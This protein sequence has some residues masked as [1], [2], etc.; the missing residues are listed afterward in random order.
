MNVQGMS[1]DAAVAQAA[2]T[3][4]VQFKM[5]MDGLK[6]RLVNAPSQEKQLKKACQD[7]EAVFISKIWQQ[8]RASVPK[9]GYLHS[10]DEEMY[11]SMFD[12]EFS[13]KMAE[14]GGMGLGDMMF[15]QL[16]KKLASAS[17]D[18]LPGQGT[19]ALAPLKGVPQAEAAAAPAA[20]DPVAL[21]ES[22]VGNPAVGPSSTYEPVVSS[23]APQTLPAGALAQS[24]AAQTRQDAGV[25]ARFDD[26]T[27]RI[28]TQAAGAVEQTA[29]TAR[30]GAGAYRRMAAVPL[31]VSASPVA[32]TPGRD[33]AE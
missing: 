29:P 26:L 28:R 14:G 31:T 20:S 1:P 30:A 18:T 5:R 3:D 6:K 4:L 11:N 21:A 17:R 16:K 13:E 7:F 23:A 10:K 12:K 19:P 22:D 15:Q 25:Q 2:D 32:R 24:G 8:M 27:R 9:D 33:I